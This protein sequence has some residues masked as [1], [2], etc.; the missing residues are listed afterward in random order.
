MKTTKILFAI[1]LAVVM[2]STLPAKAQSKKELKKS[3]ENQAKQLESTKKT[4]DQL[5]DQ[6]ETQGEET[7][8]MISDLLNEVKKQNTSVSE[9]LPTSTSELILAKNQEEPMKVKELTEV[10]KLQKELEKAKVEEKFNNALVKAAKE[11]EASIKAIENRK[12][13]NNGSS[14]LKGHPILDEVNKTFTFV[15]SDTLLVSEKYEVPKDYQ[16]IVKPR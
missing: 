8:G 13:A 3:I 5:K 10:E 6:L 7:Q 1:F 15:E 9:N 2:I 14:S 11:K 12:P 16:V 4:V